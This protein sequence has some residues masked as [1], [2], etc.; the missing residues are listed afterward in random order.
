[1]SIE[2]SLSKAQKIVEQL[3][4]ATVKLESSVGA[5]NI[6]CQFRNQG[7]AAV[8]AEM[9]A[10]AEAE[11]LRLATYFAVS[12]DY[13]NAKA[14]LFSGNVRS[15]V[16]QTMSDLD[17]YKRR[18]KIWEKLECEDSSSAEFVPA[19][20]IPSIYDNY[21]KEPTAYIN[22]ST[23]L[24][25]V[26]RRVW[27]TEE[28]TAEIKSIKKEISMLEDKRDNLNHTYKV[29]ITLDPKSRELIGL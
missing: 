27:S 9:D 5:N 7:Y 1:M 21:Y 24:S 20:S 17:L 11:R 3:R 12:T 18:I 23:L 22:R 28:S 19:E 16:H 15:G 13:A 4:L 25:R 6:R 29:T 2:V 26:S 10:S 14:A 8:V